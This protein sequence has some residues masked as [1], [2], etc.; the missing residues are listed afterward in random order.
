MVNWGE[1]AA[2]ATKSHPL[3]PF[4]TSILLYV[5]VSIN[6]LVDMHF[7]LLTLG[8]ANL[9][10]SKARLFW[11]YFS[12]SFSY[13]IHTILGM[14]ILILLVCLVTV[15]I[16]AIIQLFAADREVAGGAAEYMKAVGGGVMNIVLQ[17]M[18]TVSDY[19]MNVYTVKTGNLFMKPFNL[20]KLPDIIKMFII[21][22]PIFM[23]SMMGSYTISFYKPIIRQD[24][25]TKKSSVM[26]TTHHY[27]FF[28]LVLFIVTF[29]GIFIYT[30]M[31]APK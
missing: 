29:I 10:V 17:R 28:L 8:A 24:E 4:A 1:V 19:I 7:R 5:L 20:Y 31:Q 18:I 2:N 13:F 14:L 23:F 26:S 27:I 11:Y 12:S 22:V 3:D 9:N 30:Y 21:V 25:E 16:T 15:I 6:S